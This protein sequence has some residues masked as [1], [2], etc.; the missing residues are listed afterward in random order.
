MYMLYVQGLLYVDPA[1]RGM[2]VCDELLMR[3]I[4]DANRDSAPFF[5]YASEHVLY[6]RHMKLLCSIL[7]FCAFSL[8]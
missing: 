8:Q 2:R 7:V 3:G 1:H 5:V 6:K 4:G